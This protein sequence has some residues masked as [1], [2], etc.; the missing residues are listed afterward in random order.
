MADAG[1]TGVGESLNRS[2]SLVILPGVVPGGRMPG[3][4]NVCQQSAIAAKE[5]QRLVV[6]SSYP[7]S[8]FAS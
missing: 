5:R 7:V 2:A 4:T 3:C 1:P 6:K 8:A